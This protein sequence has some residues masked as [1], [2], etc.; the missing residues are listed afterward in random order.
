MTVQPPSPPPLAPAVAA[1]EPSLE[2]PETL[3]GYAAA[4]L[5]GIEAAAEALTLQLDPTR[6]AFNAVEERDTAPAFDAGRAWRGVAIRHDAVA[7]AVHEGA[8]VDQAQLTRWLDLEAG[9]VRSIDDRVDRLIGLDLHAALSIAGDPAFPVRPDRGDILAVLQEGRRLSEET[10]RPEET[11]LCAAAADLLDEIE[12]RAPSRDRLLRVLTVGRAFRAL[13]RLAGEQDRER[14]R[15]GRLAGLLAPSIGRRFAWPAAPPLLFV[16]VEMQRRSKRI[17]EVI[18]GAD[19]AARDD[20]AWDGLWVSM[21]EDAAAAGSERLRVMGDLWR[22]WL[23][24]GERGGGLVQGKRRADRE[25][26]L[27]EFLVSPWL[28]RATA[29]DRLG[30]SDSQARR[31]LDELVALDLLRRGFG[32]QGLRIWRSPQAE[33]IA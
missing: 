7:L 21:V 8:E 11:A 20:T 16:G 6:G 25:R 9:A 3:S 23:R 19:P 27:T 22:A 1:P 29:A 31:R 30:L 32:Y 4:R 2:P 18:S 17:A 26:A 12:D 28:S 5:A 33:K 13:L 15:T 10:L 24:A 14:L